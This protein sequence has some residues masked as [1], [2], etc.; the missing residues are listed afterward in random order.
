[1]HVV[2]IAPDFSTTGVSVH[3][4]QLNR[5]LVANGH[6]VTIAPLSVTRPRI[7]CFR[8]GHRESTPL[9]IQRVADWFDEKLALAETYARAIE[10][11]SK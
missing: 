6:D 2:S 9:N 3:V 7:D 4:E 10:D 1:M 11:L 5:H 8:H